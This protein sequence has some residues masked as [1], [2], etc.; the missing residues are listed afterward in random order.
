MG[1]SSRL[2]SVLWGAEEAIH[3]GN[4][5]SQNRRCH[6]ETQVCERLEEGEDISG[7]TE[8]MK[9]LVARDSEAPNTS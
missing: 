4:S 8:E 7:E 2:S 6:I 5:R 9:L 1:P 3:L